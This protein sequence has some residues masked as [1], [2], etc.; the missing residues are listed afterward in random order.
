MLRNWT[1]ACSSVKMLF[2]HFYCCL[3]LFWS[4]SGNTERNRKD[5]RIPK[6]LWMTAIKRNI[7]V[8]VCWN[9]DEIFKVFFKQFQIFYVLNVTVRVY[10][11]CLHHEFGKKVYPWLKVNIGFCHNRSWKV[12]HS[13][14]EWSFSLVNTVF[15]SE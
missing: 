13:W 10:M 11:C 4:K 12:I 6:M 1:E 14:S 5:A 8:D 9:F 3:V 7:F 2:D 15:P